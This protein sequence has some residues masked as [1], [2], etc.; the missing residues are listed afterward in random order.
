MT[1]EQYQELLEAH[2]KIMDYY[3]DALADGAPRPMEFALRR[4]LDEMEEA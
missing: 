3:D 2:I 4:M 1:N